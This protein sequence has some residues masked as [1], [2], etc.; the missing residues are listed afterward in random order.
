MNWI[1]VVVLI[2]CVIVL[3]LL[4][5]EIRKNVNTI[6]YLIEKKNSLEKS[7]VVAKKWHNLK[8]RYT[9]KIVI[10]SVIIVAIIILCVVFTN[11]TLKWYYSIPGGLL[12]P[13]LG[14]WGIIISDD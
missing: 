10:F 9:F 11:N 3:W 1:V 2:V 8:R 13:F 6:Q 7:Y 12:V 5:F 4:G 14:Y